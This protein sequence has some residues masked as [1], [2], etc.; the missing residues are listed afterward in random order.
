MNKEQI[1]A[2]LDIASFYQTQIPSLKVNVK[3]NAL[4]L[5]PFHDDH[6][7][8]F[9]VNVETGLFNCF[10]CGE[11]GDIFTFYRE[12]HGVDFP[13]A[14]RDIGA[15]VEVADTNVK[16][17]VVATFRY[18]DYEGKLLYIKER[19]E[20]G[21]NGRSKEFIFKHQEGDRW[22][23]GRGCDPVLY[24]LPQVAKSKCCSIAEGESKADLLT[25]WG[26]VATCFDSGANSPIK[27]KD[28]QILGSKEEMFIF[29]D[30]DK[31]GKEHA[32]KRANVLYGKGRR[33]KV[34]ELPGLKEGEDIIDW[35]KIPGND[36]AK[37]LEIIKNTPEWIPINSVNE[38]DIL[39][40]EVNEEYEAEESLVF[41]ASAWRGVFGDYREAMEGTT[42]A[43]DVTHF[44][45][46]WAVSATIF[47][48]RV[49]LSYGMDLYPNVYLVYFGNTGDKKTTATT[50][51]NLLLHDNPNVKVLQG[52]GSGEGLTDWL[53]TE[54]TP[55]SHFLYLSELSELLQKGK[56][57]GATLKTVLTQIYDCP[58]VY[59]APFRKNPIKIVEPTLTLLACTTPTW[60]WKDMTEL[61][62]HGGF[63]NRICY[64]T[65]VPNEPIARPCKPNME[66][67]NKVRIH[68][69]DSL[70]DCTLELD[71][72]PE[73]AK[74][75]DEFYIKW[76]K[77]DW[78]PLV[79]E[80][81]KRVDGYILKLAMVYAVLE[82]TVPYITCDQLT[83]AIQ[84]GYYAAKCTEK[85]ITQHRIKSKTVRLEDRI[86]E[87]L[88]KRDCPRRVLQRTAGTNYDSLIFNKTLEAMV[89]AHRIYEKPGERSNQ[90]LYS[91]KPG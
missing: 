75:W 47:R 80:A 39:P 68:I 44:V 82:G 61:D 79:K 38:A 85:L 83:S 32:I 70:P 22:G 77:E 87:E 64:F 56:W 11:K 54:D 14:L 66:L 67:L 71:F 4:G 50:K 65:G 40:K 35:A 3:P 41:P 43:S 34:V 52:I 62:I 55:T 15:M 17:K 16:P 69:A 76:V 51:S 31:P 36:K 88:K 37:L 23:L 59:E 26:F 84:V 20:P 2:N 74:L 46:L 48:R 78:E 1:L 19:I 90:R 53:K 25:K 29:P 49:K 42:W 24:N 10:S 18:F 9:S 73:S 5:C 33:L 86:I 28:I 91:L 58:S 60:F 81:V 89:R 8:S 7:P 30:N 27:D 12:L 21:R 63:A 13:T 72:D 45:T 6:N 57:E